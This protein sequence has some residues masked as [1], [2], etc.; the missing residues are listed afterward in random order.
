MMVAYS[1]SASAHNGEKDGNDSIYDPI[2]G[3]MNR[4]KH[5]CRQPGCPNLTAEKYC[6][7]HSHLQIKETKTQRAR[8]DAKRNPNVRDL[9][10]ARWARYSMRFRRQ[11]PL[12]AIC[13]REGRLTAT[14]VTDHIIP[15]RGD[16]VLFWDPNNHQ[17][18]CKPCHDSKTQSEGAWGRERKTG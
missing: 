6:Q 1:I 18:A 16:Y 5:P 10:D 12:C 15:H 4:A 13:E 7:M 3:T 14:E 17:P 2:R 11:H 8:A 9:Y